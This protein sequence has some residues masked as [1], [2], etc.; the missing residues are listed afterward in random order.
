MLPFD[1]CFFPLTSIFKPLLLLSDLDILHYHLSVSIICFF[2]TLGVWYDRSKY[3]Q[4]IPVIGIVIT[5][6][7]KNNKTIKKVSGQVA[8]ESTLDI[9]NPW[10]I[11]RIF[12][13]AFEHT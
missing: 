5:Y 2:S 1:M 4:A 7:R 9:S 11:G 10:K 12:F 8:R 13:V 6:D 3:L